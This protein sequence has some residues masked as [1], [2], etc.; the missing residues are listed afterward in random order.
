MPILEND[1]PTEV[2]TVPERKHGVCTYSYFKISVRD[3]YP[4]T[5]VTFV[6]NDSEEV[7]KQFLLCMEKV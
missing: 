4:S 6:G 3:S 2:V 5:T 7:M 1:K